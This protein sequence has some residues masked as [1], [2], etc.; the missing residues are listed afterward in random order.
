MIRG[1]QL[2]LP[3]IIC[4]ILATACTKRVL[5]VKSGKVK[6]PTPV[7]PVD[8]SYKLEWEDNFDT[9]G[10]NLDLS[11][12]FHRA[13]GPRRDGF[14]N[15]ES[16]S[17]DKDG[18]MVIT[19]FSD[20]IG[21]VVRHSSG[22]IATHTNFLY[23]KFEARVS[24]KNRPGAWFAFWIQSP[25][26]GNPVGNTAVAGTEIDVVEVKPTTGRPV[27]SLVWDGYGPFYK[28]S[29]F[30]SADINAN[31]GDYH[32][33][34]VEWTALGY[35]YYVDDKLVWET[36]AAISKRPQFVILS[37]EVWHNDTWAGRIPANGFGSKQ[38][39]TSIAK[40]DWVRYYRYK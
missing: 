9:P 40:V 28:V 22:M 38:R 29:Q 33:Y 12:W 17:I 13:P 14:N 34:G 26:I 2:W 5:L 16:V 39:S 11:K 15:S 1:R 7:L 30:A 36:T 32:V 20:T 21:G 27:H 10:G 37:C 23:G 18:N 6:D 4:S 25:T 24:V 35:K 31:N 8:S 3:V 19:T